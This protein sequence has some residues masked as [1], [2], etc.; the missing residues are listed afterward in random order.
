VQQP[1]ARQIGTA[2]DVARGAGAGV[3]KGTEGLI[4]TP[5]SVARPIVGAGS[6]LIERGYDPTGG[7]RFGGPEE[8]PLGQS[9]GPR[10]MTPEEVEKH[11]QQAGEIE[12]ALPGGAIA[13]G[14]KTATGGAGDYQP[15][16]GAGRFAERAGEF[17]PSLAIPG[18]GITSRLAEGVGGKL[19][20]E[21][22]RVIGQ[23]I[24]RGVEN[25][26]LPAAG[27]M[28]GGKI[29]EEIG[30]PELGA[31]IGGIAGGL[32]GGY[33]G[34]RID[35]ETIAAATK[36]GVKVPLAG[37]VEGKAIPRIA[38]TLENVPFAGA[39]LQSSA[40]KAISDIGG[41][42]SSAEAA[43]GATTREAAGGKAKSAI[44]DWITGK[45]ADNVKAAYDKAESLMQPGA[46][47]DASNARAAIADI[48]ARRAASGAR[49]SGPAIGDILEGVQR[50]GGLT[51]GGLKDMRTRM[52]Q[53]VDNK[54][55]TDDWQQP[56]VKQL[57]GAL[58]QD[59]ESA[60]AHAGGSQGAA[61]WQR[62]NT[63]AKA[64]QSRRESLVKLV[65]K[66]GDASPEAVFDN[67]AQLASEGAGGNRQ[68]LAQAMRTVGA[69][70]WQEI[71]GTIGARLGRD[72]TIGGDTSLQKFLTSYS[73]MSD[74]GKD[75]LFGRAGQGDLRQAYDEIATL[76]KR[77]NQLNKL[78][79]PSGTAAHLGV[80]STL[81]GL[82]FQP[83]AT[84]GVLAGGNLLSHVLS[85][86]ATAKPFARLVR[87]AQDDA[88]SS[89]LGTE[90]I[91]AGVAV[92][93]AARN[94]ANTANS[95]LGTNLTPDQ[96]RNSFGSQ[97]Q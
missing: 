84:I 31:A 94:F 33:R 59:L 50:P 79:N 93:A 56:E 20:G 75:M 53:R 97:S 29:G 89:R 87:A 82:W 41:A 95:Q 38:K 28:V 69:K 4:T 35:P 32:A 23:G 77:E 24:G 45:S 81:G 96:V 34:P 52:G 37:A 46:T 54:L 71:A 78:K 91:K 18:V 47:V 70:D 15:T 76:G 12:R 49:G 72:P 8:Q 17:A 55:L 39:P 5:E 58:S 16:T 13:G 19:A 44:N 27:S 65:G 66:G 61:A 3:I 68:R 85:Q 43:A 63:L 60:A 83:H 30:H 80:L 36:L 73:K 2:E 1:P 92:N 90:G 6:S 67:I 51:Y 74:A 48:M 7:L 57:Y 86:P 62:A 40:E 11:R 64:T 14:I 26:A 25:I 10:P 22:G 21:A 88:F 9:G 42:K